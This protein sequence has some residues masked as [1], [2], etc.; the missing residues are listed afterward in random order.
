MIIE[1]TREFMI[2]CDSFRIECNQC[3]DWSNV[4]S[5]NDLDEFK[6]KHEHKN[7]R[8]YVQCNSEGEDLAV[9]KMT[10]DQQAVIEKFERDSAR[11]RQ[12]RKENEG[13]FATH[14]EMMEAYKKE[15]GR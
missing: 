10:Y 11:K 9:V 4:L 2:S 6:A 15:F 14:E 8:F 3:G 12:W 7:E 1:S 5:R 13:K